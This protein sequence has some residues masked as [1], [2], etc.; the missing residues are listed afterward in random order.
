M[1]GKEVAMAAKLNKGISSTEPKELTVTGPER[2]LAPLE[3]MERWMEDAFRRPFFAP[4]WM[5][6][7]KLPEIMGEVSPSVDIFEDGSDV[8]VK[9]E[10][11]GMKK[12][13]I[14][15]NLT[16]DTITITGQKK[17]ETKIEK[18]DFYRLECSFGSFCRKLRLPSDTLT[19]RA[20]ASFKDGILEVRIP[21][22]PTAKSRKIAID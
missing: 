20:K 18:K 2:F 10:V 15:V 6:R 11:P 8:V 9:A 21:K 13:D 17:G 22:S 7:L 12:E 19:D 4:S 14:E 3:E 5:P 16:P 1:I